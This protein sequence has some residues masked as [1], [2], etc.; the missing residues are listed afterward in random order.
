MVLRV[1]YF[2]QDGRMAC[3]EQKPILEEVERNCNIAADRINPL[4]N[5]AA[6]KEFRLSVTPT[7]VILKNGTEV[8]RFEGLVHR[9]PLEEAI[10]RFYIG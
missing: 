10:R 9:E 2:F 5:R 1:I 8:K 7:I 4:K 6:I 3:H